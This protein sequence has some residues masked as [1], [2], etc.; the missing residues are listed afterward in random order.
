[1]PMLPSHNDACLSRVRG[2]KQ[3]DTVSEE[4]AIFS[5]KTFSNINL[6]NKAVLIVPLKVNIR[7]AFRWNISSV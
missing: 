1:M 4:C 7:K 2:F 5:K 3:S 6:L